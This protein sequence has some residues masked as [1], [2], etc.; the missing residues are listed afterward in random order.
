MTLRSQFRHK[1]SELSSIHFSTYSC[2]SN[3][4]D[5]QE[6]SPVRF[7]INSCCFTNNCNTGHASFQVVSSGFKN[8]SFLL[9]EVFCLFI[10]IQTEYF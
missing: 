8:V 3:C 4:K 5:S 6:G 9:M 2:V 10:L 7:K 1:N